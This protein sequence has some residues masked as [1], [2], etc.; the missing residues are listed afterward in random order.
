MKKTLIMTLASFAFLTVC[1]LVAFFTGSFIGT[2]VDYGL[3]GGIL[4]VGLI[5]LAVSGVIA[6]FAKENIPL[7]IF[8][9]LLSAVALGFCIRSWYIFRGLENDFYVMVLVSLAAASVLLV[10][11]L[12]SRIPFFGQNIIGYT[13]VFLILALG[14]YI[15]AVIFTRTTF[16][17]TLGYYMLIEIA[18]VYAFFAEADGKR[19][20]LRNF[21]LSTYS[22]L[23]IAV[24]I[25]V[26][27]LCLVGGDGDCDCDCSDCCDCCDCQGAGGGS[28]TK[29]KKKRT[30]M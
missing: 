16:L 4:T 30:K 17:S 24:I 13:F 27:V 2:G 25:V 28:N 9:S 15:P 12:L 6:F 26:I 3:A 11:F 8:C 7:N 1:S 20:F 14:A 21:T 29:R 22:V 10:Y 19:S 5:I 23:G 18:F